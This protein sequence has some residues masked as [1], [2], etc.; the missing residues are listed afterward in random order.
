[1]A[2]CNWVVDS[3]AYSFD[4]E[5]PKGFG[6]KGCYTC[7]ITDDDREFD[8]HR[9]NACT[10][11]WLPGGKPIPK[12][13]WPIELAEPVT[14]PPDLDIPEL[15]CDDPKPPGPLVFIVGGSALKPVIAQVAQHF[16]QETQPDFGPPITVI[17][18]NSAGCDGISLVVVDHGEISGTAFR[19]SADPDAK[20]IPC[21]IPANTK[22]DI[23]AATAFAESCNRQFSGIHKLG[24]IETLAFVV[25]LSS[26]QHSISADA[27]FNVYGWGAEGDVSP[28]KVETQLFQRGPLSGTQAAVAKLIG[29]PLERKWK[30]RSEPSTD[31][32][33]LQIVQANAA[34]GAVAD[35]TLG[36]ASAAYLLDRRLSDN[37]RSLAFQAPGQRAAF[38]PSST[39][40][41]TDF[42]NVRKGRY[43]LWAPYHFYA[44][45]LPAG[46]L[47]DG[48]EKVLNAL[49]GESAPPGLDMIKTYKEQGLIARCAMEVDVD[50]DGGLLKAFAGRS[51][52]CYWDFLLKKSPSSCRICSD[53]A[54]CAGLPKTPSCNRYGQNS[55]FCE[56]TPP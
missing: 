40:D 14:P 3:G 29:L 8:Q 46:R 55:R 12:R 31:A 41:G 6:G 5:N 1:M 24:P 9:L 30:G 11:D 56:A 15:A 38:L 37:V 45:R 49:T 13:G 43:R 16:A 52:S 35:Q 19:W 27:A 4:C 54:D 10:P 25:P 51:C 26:M 34:G 7:T 50:S 39:P 18:K 36:F 47:P 48:V 28:W 2:G 22:P 32:L 20:A 53:K 33:F 17:F 23:A 21:R 42:V 44:R